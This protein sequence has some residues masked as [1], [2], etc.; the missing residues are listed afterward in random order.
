MSIL[1][2]GGAGYIGSHTAV[3]L[4][5]KG[6]EVVIIDNL[7]NSSKIAIERIEEITGKRVKFY[8][9]DIRDK[10]ALTKIFTENKIEAVIHFAGLKAV[11]ESAIIPLAYYENNIAGTICLIEQMRENGVNKLVFSSSACVYGDI[12][13]PPMV[14]T[15]QTTATNP[16][17]WTKVMLEQIMRDVCASDKNFSVMALR[18]FNPVGAHESG[19]IGEDP[20]DIPNNLPPYI[21]QTLIGKREVL[22][23]FGDD[24]PTADGTCIRDY[25]HVVD[26]AEGHIL[27]IDYMVKNP[28]FSVFNLGRGEGESTFGM[29]KAFEAASGRKVNYVIGP[30]RPNNADVPVSYA[31]ASKAEKLLGFKAKRSILNM[32]EDAWRWQTKN[33][34]G[35]R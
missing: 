23:V 31:D 5:N 7:D 19:L 9:N 26:L 24:Y 22:T 14:E 12:N 11:D 25:I 1:I 35:F 18:Y 8:E 30:R 4:L 10:N 27:A 33:P 29:I 28:G 16:Y 3:S 21:T 17:G 15:M 20:N 13:Q 34:E 6:E 32:C 2:A